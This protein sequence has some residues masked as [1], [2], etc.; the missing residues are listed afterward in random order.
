MEKEGMVGSKL[1]VIH[2][3][4][5]QLDKFKKVGLGKKTE[6][7]TIVTEKLIEATERRLEELTIVYDSKLTYNAIKLRKIKHKNREKLL[8]DNQSNCNGTTTA[9][10]MQNKRNT[11]LKRGKQ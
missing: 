11:R 9:S 5:E 3:Y 1:W 7:G 2:M 4:Q 8:N 6:H 10:R